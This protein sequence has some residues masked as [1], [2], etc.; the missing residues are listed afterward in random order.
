MFL[1]CKSNILHKETCTITFSGV[2]EVFEGG[3]VLTCFLLGLIVGA[4]YLIPGTEAVPSIVHTKRP[5][6]MNIT[7]FWYNYTKENMQTRRLMRSYK[8]SI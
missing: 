3:E 6:N 4:I 1:Q 7:T 2:S 5:P 8:L